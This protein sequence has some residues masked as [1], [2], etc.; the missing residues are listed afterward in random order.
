LKRHAVDVIMGG[1]AHLYQRG[2]GLDNVTYMIVGGGGGELEKKN[3]RIANY[4]LYEKV[5]FGYHY[6]IMTM[7]QGNIHFSAYNV[8]NDLI[9]QFSVP[10]VNTV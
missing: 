5:Y 4:H 9:D 8:S 1:H 2:R 6:L 3:E 7:T 10:F